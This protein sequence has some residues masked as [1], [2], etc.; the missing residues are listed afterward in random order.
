MKN[1]RSIMLSK[2]S[3]LPLIFI[4]GMTKQIANSTILTKY[5]QFVY[6]PFGFLGN[7]HFLFPVLSIVPIES[8]N[9]SASTTQ[10]SASLYFFSVPLI[11]FQIKKEIV[12]KTNCF[13]FIFQI[14]F[15]IEQY[16]FDNLFC[17]LSCLRLIFP[18]VLLFLAEQRH[19][20]LR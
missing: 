9:V 2:R 7:T 20:A 16:F 8:L 11:I 14:S 10:L 13:Q 4:K 12:Q 6:F 5:L 17:M 15:L 3:G 1:W 18:S 19:L